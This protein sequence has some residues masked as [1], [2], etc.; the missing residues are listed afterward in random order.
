ML[1]RTTIPVVLK[2]IHVTDF[3][4]VC[5]GMAT[6]CQ[7]ERQVDKTHPELRLLE[8]AGWSSRRASWRDSPRTK[9]PR[10]GWLVTNVTDRTTGRD[11]IIDMST[12]KK[13]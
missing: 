9:I 10:G 8:E 3:K 12:S 1:L 6:L 2:F 5:P 7:A 11:D 4:G 13:Q